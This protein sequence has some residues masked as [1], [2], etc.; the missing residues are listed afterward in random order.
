[1]SEGTNRDAGA[2]ELGRAFDQI[3]AAARELGGDVRQSGSLS[4]MKDALKDVIDAHDR[5]P[6][7]DRLKA[8]VREM[9]DDVE[10]GGSLDRLKMAVTDFGNV[11]ERSARDQW[12]A[13]K[14]ELKHSARD[15]Q[16]LVDALSERAREAI[17]SLGSRLDPP[18][19][20]R[21]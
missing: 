15:L 12:D 8:T 16:R 21:S 14:P 13:A 7:L 3:K 5:G 20:R 11:A 6:V 4:K 2:G 17:D 10:A 19:K 18:D 9:G 1:M